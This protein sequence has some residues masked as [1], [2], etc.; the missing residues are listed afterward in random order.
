[1]RAS[2]LIAAHNEGDSLWKTIRSCV[3]GCARLDYEIVVADDASTDGSVHSAQRRYPQI[4]VVRNKRRQGASPT[5]HLAACNARGNALVFLDGHCSPE[6][7]AIRR[8]VDDVE[9]LSGQAII[10]PSIPALCPKTWR[11]KSTQVGHGYRL[12]LEKFD[13]AWLPL[14]KLRV[15]R[16]GSRKFYESP[17]LI[18]CAWP[19]PANCTTSCMASIRTCF[20][21]AWRTSISASAHGCRATQFCTTRR[22]QSATVSGNRSTTTMCRWITWW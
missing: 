21:G 9:E 18:G 13:C 10:T 6:P 4:R 19:S 15:R 20:I 12:G 7:G 5:K 3:E 14:D 1:M 17:A 11:N 22:Q 2:L 8:L 16:R